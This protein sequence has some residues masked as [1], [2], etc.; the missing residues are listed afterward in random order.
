M[1]G[2]SGGKSVVFFSREGNA[3]EVS[4]QSLA[5]RPLL[6]EDPLK[7]MGK[8]RR[9]YCAQQHMVAGPA[10]IRAFVPAVQPPS[11]GEH[12]AENVLISAPGYSL[13]GPFRARISMAGHG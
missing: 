8:E 4:R 13:G 9:R 3:A 5:I 11:C 12:Q 7:K 2:M 1:Q 6:V 10:V